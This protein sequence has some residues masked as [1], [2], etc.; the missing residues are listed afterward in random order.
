M[1]KLSIL[2]IMAGTTLLCASP[3]SPQLS[4]QGKL[5][6]SLDTANA[7]IGRPWTATSIAGVNRRVARRTARR[8][9]YADN[10]GYQSGLGAGYPYNA[11]SG[12]YAAGTGVGF[13]V[14]TGFGLGTGYGF[15]VAPRY[16][17]AAGTGYYGDGT[18]YGVGTG[19]RYGVAPR[20]AA[21]A[22]AMGNDS[23]AARA[24]RPGGWFGAWGGNT[25]AGT[26]NVATTN[27][28]Y[29]NAAYTNTGG[30]ARYYYGNV[31]P[32]RAYVARGIL[33]GSYYGPVCNP[34]SDRS[35]Q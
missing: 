20:A 1:R 9:Y 7:A 22:Y 8:A 32:T 16:R 21:A 27:A 24:Y 26:S 28:G 25:N 34:R 5:S 18:G 23:Y 10:Y 19:Y 11:A 33:S 29:V 35:C 13:G 15:G 31:Y 6:V 14:G 2:G 4:P 30:D 17:Y 3:V 12:Y